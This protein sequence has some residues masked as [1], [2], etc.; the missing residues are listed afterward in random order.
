MSKELLQNVIDNGVKDNLNDF[1]LDISNNYKEIDDNLSGYDDERFSEFRTLGEMIF[2]HTEKL[3]VV[4]AEVAND[5]TE[6]SGKKAQY[7]KAKK[8]LKDYM[9][10]DAGIF[11][12]LDN[13]GCFRFSLVYGQAEGT[14]KSYSNFRRFTYFV[15]PEQTNK[16][17][18]DRVGTCDFSSLDLVKEAFSVEKVTKDFY[19]K[20]A[21][22]YFWAVQNVVFP[23]DVEQETNGRNNAVIRMI[24][25]LIFIWFMRERGL[26]SPALFD[27]LKIEKLLKDTSP[28]SSSY[29]KAILQN[30]FFATLNTKIEDRKFRFAKSYH[31]RNDDYMDHGVYRYEKYFCHQ[32]DM[33]EIFK[34]IPFLNGGLFDCLDRRI[35]Q[36][37]K[38]AEIRID[39]FTDKEVGLS[40]TNLL[41]FADETE[42][43]LNDEYGTNNKK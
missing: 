24:T 43:D 32:E 33:L 39:G 1:F 3:V 35:T 4:T 11:V 10:Y 7:E 14:K 41:F 27:F 26:V 38:N 8:I 12:F 15:S 5:L 40:V 28:N 20:I 18:K 42:A 9:K 29:Y 22:W 21:D 13:T 31:G 30:L 6:R 34:G 25:R 36:D 2:N 37:G 16:T 19:K 17:F 23:K